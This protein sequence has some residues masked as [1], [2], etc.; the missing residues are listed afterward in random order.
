MMTNLYGNRHVRLVALHGLTMILLGLAVFYVR[1]TMT[2]IFFDFIGGLLA[3][4]LIAASLIFLALSDWLIVFDL[5]VGEVSKLRR[6]LTLSTLAAAGSLSMM[7]YPAASTRI[8]CYFVAV[9]ALVLGIGKLYLA[10]H[11]VGSQATQIFM[12]ILAAIAL[13][14]AGVLVGAAGLTEWLAV[15]ILAIY[16]LFTGLQMLLCMFFLL[17]MSGSIEVSTDRTMPRTKHA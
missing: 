3:F 16:C 6:L 10:A 5:G 14:F 7:F 8:L 11:W 15:T 13:S 4:L 17:R 2:N 9:Y 12:W 1:N